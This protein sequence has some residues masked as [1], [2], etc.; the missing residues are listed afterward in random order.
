VD[1]EVTG[2][3]ALLTR[4]AGY[5]VPRSHPKAVECDMLSSS[6]TAHEQAGIAKHV[7]IRGTD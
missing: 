6:S 2:S 3:A 1:G 7:W 5:A 4:A